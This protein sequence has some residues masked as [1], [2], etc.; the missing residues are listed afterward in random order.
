MN[1][2]RNYDGDYRGLCPIDT[3]VSY[4]VRT[5]IDRPEAATFGREVSA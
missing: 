4:L 2:D 1:I 5:T 3:D